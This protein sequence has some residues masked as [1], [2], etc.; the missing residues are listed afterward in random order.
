M[1]QLVDKI[2]GGRTIE[3]LEKLLSRFYSRHNPEKLP[4]ITALA[5][6]FL[7]KEE[8]LN[9]L[10]KERYDADL[11]DLLLATQGNPESAD[12]LHHP[13]DQD[14]MVPGNSCEDPSMRSQYFTQ[15]ENS[16]WDATMS[17]M[18][19]TVSKADVSNGANNLS[20]IVKA[21][22]KALKA[23]LQ[24]NQELKAINADLCVQLEQR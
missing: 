21:T 20:A 1:N 16:K 7:G 12:G 18:D 9:K 24:E 3:E 22:S 5:Q 15:E 2:P 10:L 8:T 17:S 13:Q 6:Q 19:S 23:A 14:S 4:T 11:N